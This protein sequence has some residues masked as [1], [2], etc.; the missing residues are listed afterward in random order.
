[1]D[2]EEYEQFAEETQAE[3]VVLVLVDLRARVRRAVTDARAARATEAS[4]LAEEQLVTTRKMREDDAAMR[5]RIR[6]AWAARF[7]NRS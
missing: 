4:A 5:E 3:R 7:A 6:R 1:M 2:S